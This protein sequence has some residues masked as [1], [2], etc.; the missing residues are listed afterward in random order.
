MIVSL[1]VVI[2][3]ALGGGILIGQNVQFG[4][5]QSRLTST[6]K[7]HPTATAA[8]KPVAPATTTA[9]L[10]TQ[11]ANLT[12]LNQ[13]SFADLD[14]L[15]GIGPVYAQ[16]IISGRPYQSIT[17]LLNRKIIPISAYNKIK[18]LISVN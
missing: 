5:P 18:D 17:D 6:S 4:T 1:L 13:A 10:S 2:G 15:P 9:V 7:T 14:S 11:K 16:K 3:I 8:V 12:N